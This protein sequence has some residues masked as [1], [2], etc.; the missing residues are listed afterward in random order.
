MGS[1]FYTN[2]TEIKFI[3]KENGEEAPFK[4][5]VNPFTEIYRLVETIK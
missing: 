2:Y 1:S 3:D 4:L 5:A